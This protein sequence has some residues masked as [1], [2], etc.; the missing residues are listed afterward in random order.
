LTPSIKAKLLLYIAQVVGYYINTA[1][2][3]MQ[4]IVGG[5]GLQLAVFIEQ[6][7]DGIA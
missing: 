5:L 4:Q 7:L 1:Q 3:V 6:G 2:M